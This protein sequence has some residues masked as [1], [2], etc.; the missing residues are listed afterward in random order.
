MSKNEVEVSLDITGDASEIDD[1]E[2]NPSN[3]NEKTD[4][5]ESVSISKSKIKLINQLIKNTRENIDKISKLMEG[6]I[7]PEEEER[8]S[9]GQSIDNDSDNTDPDSRVIEGV[10]DGEG[11]IG[12]D[13]KQY[14]V[15][16]NYASKSKLVEGDI[17]KL[18]ITNNG[19]FIY[20]QI[21]PIERARKVGI[22]E[23]NVNGN[24]TV[25]AESKKWK[26]L[27]ASVTYYKGDIGDEVIVLVPKSGE[28]KWGAVDNI[29]KNVK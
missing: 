21:A 16:A 26:V 11:M 15:P 10:F 4:S 2:I 29:V 22:L 18:S 7:T 23:Q 19:T 28:S 13:G 3:Q 27:T 17:L 1:L 6:Q 24:F 14:S 25:N 8:I 9:V 20:K 5:D 12:P